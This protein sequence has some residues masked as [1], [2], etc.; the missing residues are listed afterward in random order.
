MLMLGHPEG[1][2][3]KQLGTEDV[4]LYDAFEELPDQVRAEYE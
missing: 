3:G 2:Y 4:R 1:R